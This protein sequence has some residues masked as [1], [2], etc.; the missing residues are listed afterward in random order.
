MLIHIKIFD[1]YPELKP[2]KN[3]PAISI[4]YDP[5]DLENPS[6]ITAIK[7]GTLFHNNPFFL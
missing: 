1:P 7:T 6:K 2:M 5:H 3:R 4:S